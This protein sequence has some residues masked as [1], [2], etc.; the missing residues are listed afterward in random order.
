MLAYSWKY[1][2]LG[3]FDLESYLSWSPQ[4]R[5]F[6]PCRF[7]SSIS[8]R[9]FGCFHRKPG[10]PNMITYISSVMAL[11][12]HICTLC[13]CCVAFLPGV[14]TYQSLGVATHNI[15]YCL[16]ISLAV[17]SVPC[18]AKTS[19]CVI[20]SHMK[21]LVRSSVSTCLMS[22]TI[23]TVHFRGIDGAA[24]N[25]AGSSVAFP[26]SSIA[27]GALQ[28]DRGLRSSSVS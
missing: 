2:P 21:Y 22:S 25:V 10:G 18:D 19:L 20:L 13:Q 8:C 7:H 4:K 9:I 5:T 28:E 12:I 16:C 3:V 24:I 23:S 17:Y 26:R 11:S 6:M 14:R 15:S 27:R 1:E